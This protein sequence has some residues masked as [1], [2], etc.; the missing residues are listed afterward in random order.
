[1]KA[2]VLYT[3]LFFLLG[4]FHLI[5]QQ[6]DTLVL[7]KTDLLSNPD[8]LPPGA[9]SLLLSADSIPPRFSGIRLSKDSLDAPVE[10]SSED[11]MIYDI[12]GQ[13]I[14]LYG[15][16]EVAYQTITL[17]AAH[18]VF[19]WSTNIV[20]AAGM[21]DSLGR[22]SGIPEFADG[23]QQFTADS[24]R[25]NFDTR[26]GIVYDVRTEY[27]DIV[28]HGSKAK[29]VSGTPTSDTTSTD[30]II[31]NQ[32]AIFTTCTDPDPHFGIRS[33]KQ[34]VVPDKLVVV[35]PSNLEI[36]GVPTPLWL[37]FGFFPI[38]KGRST[39][40]L[41]PRDYEYSPQWGFGLRDIGWYFPLGEHF[42]VSLK[43]N[44]YV[45]GTWGLGAE[46]QYAKRYKYS[47]S[48]S[49]AFDK[50]RVENAEGLI[51]KQKSFSLRWTHNQAATAHP[52]SRFGGSIN[53]QTNDYQS[54]V[55]N[56]ADNVLQSQLSSN[57]SY[58]KNWADKPISLSV[59]FNH[60]QNTQS[61]EVTVNFPTIDFQTRTIYP[62][63]SKNS[64]GGKRPW[65]QDITMR[66]KMQAKS[67]FRGIDTTFFEQETWDQA[68]FGVQQDVSTGTSFKILRYFNLNPNVSYKEVSY[69]RSL[70][71]DYLDGV[72]V[73]ADTTFNPIT[74][75]QEIDISKYGTVLDTIVTGYESYR[76]LSA[77]V[78]LT[79]QVFG[80]MRFK[81]GWLRGVRHVIKPTFT[82]GYQP[83]YLNNP[84]YYRFVRDP[85]SSPDD[86]EFDQYSIFENGIYGRPPASEQQMAL[87]YS[88]TNIFEGKYFSRRDSTEKKFK[89]FDNIYINGQYNFAADTLKWSRVNMSGTTRFFKGI[90]TLSARAIFD[91]Y[92]QERNENDVFVRVNKSAWRQ[93]GKLLDFVNASASLNT[94]LTVSKIRA[95]FQG[96]EEE[97]VE[98]VQ[99]EEERQRS[100]RR[101]ETDFL[102]LFENF[103]ISHNIVFNLDRVYKDDNVFKDTF[104]IRTH[105]IDL[106]GNI[107]LTEKWRINISRIGYDFVRKQLTYPSLGFSRDLHC[108]EMTMNWAPTRG[109]YSFS[110]R[111]KP[112]TL[113]FIKLPYER[114]NADAIR[115]FQ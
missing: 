86:P 106:R 12:A 67:T 109:T 110:I 65:Y 34:K 105:S 50:R 84:N 48:A 38:S 32:D 76:T 6:P 115:A 104:N 90:T 31:Y 19:D 112:G 28:V 87:S 5:G 64:V 35:G 21:P 41:F 9:D 27:T 66:Y 81:K 62:F 17:K 99:E 18:I 60:S 56:D 53:F 29:F 100:R 68:Q 85:Y 59:A 101:E 72:D 98:N 93:R 91:P 75:E 78:S 1:M 49:I 10:Y 16:A 40:L 77:G 108:W 51:D 47:G 22:R 61:R 24:M 2:K 92:I 8:T 88:F 114:N 103:S 82:L 3:I 55:Y 54:R 37:P 15:Q 102:S 4:G 69:F 74:G 23:D 57:F 20:T 107:D 94:R 79:T 111:V 46:T 13:K 70:R 14:H 39:G 44:I 30:D 73:E 42:N 71:K 52:T 26:K 36:M 80:T 33:K 58:S 11:S 96:Q 25:Y 43:G 83:D 97:V 7:P 63:R 95:L 113:D 89:F 45:K